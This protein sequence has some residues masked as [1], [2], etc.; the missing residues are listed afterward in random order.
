MECNYHNTLDTVLHFAWERIDAH[1]DW[2]MFDYWL[3]DESDL[4]NVYKEA[5]ELVLGNPLTAEDRR[6]VEKK[7]INLENAIRKMCSKWNREHPHIQ[8][9]RMQKDCLRQ[10]IHE[11]LLKQF[12]KP[13]IIRIIGASC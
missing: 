5:F 13:D 4:S 10:K 11:Y 8:D 6:I 7:G 1:Y 12:N 2:N 9:G 3:G